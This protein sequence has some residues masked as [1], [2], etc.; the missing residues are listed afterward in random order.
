MK[1][2]TIPSVISWLNC[3]T[4]LTVALIHFEREEVYNFGPR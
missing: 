4:Q 1:A 3:I 2:R